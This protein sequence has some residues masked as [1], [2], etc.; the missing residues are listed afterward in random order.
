MIF[1]KSMLRTCMTFVLTIVAIIWGW[2]GGHIAF[3]FHRS[4]AGNFCHLCPSS[5]AHH[6]CLYRSPYQMGKTVRCGFTESIDRLI[7][8]WLH[9]FDRISYF[10]TQS[11]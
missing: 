1:L 2:G 6:C 8:G 11:V 7:F 9:S 4:H 10:D 5:Y 3:L